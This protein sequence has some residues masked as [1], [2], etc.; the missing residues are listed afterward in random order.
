MKKIGN[1]LSLIVSVIFFIHFGNIPLSGTAAGYNE[2]RL[3]IS[4]MDRCEQYLSA[5]ELRAL[6][7]KNETVYRYFYRFDSRDQWISDHIYT[8]NMPDF[9]GFGEFYSFV[10]SVYTSDTVKKLFHDFQ[11]HGRSF[12]EEDGLF[13]ADQALTF[14]AAVPLY[15]PLDSVQIL[16]GSEQEIVF[17]YWFAYPQR[18]W[19]GESFSSESVGIK[20][21]VLKEEGEWR[22][23]EM[24][25]LNWGSDR[26]VLRD[27]Q[28]KTCSAFSPLI[29]MDLY[30]M[31]LQ[32]KIC[33]DSL[34]TGSSA[35]F[36]RENSSDELEMHLR[37]EQDVGLY[38]SMPLD[39]ITSLDIT[40]ECGCDLSFLSE[41]KA[42]TSLS[43]SNG[44]ACAGREPMESYVRSF[45]FLSSLT[46]LNRLHISGVKDF[47]LSCLSGLP[48]LN[49]IT[50]SACTVGELPPAGSPVKKLALYGCDFPTDLLRRFPDLTDLEIDGKVDDFS[51]LKETGHLR[52]L[53]LTMTGFSDIEN[54]AA[55]N[56]L[57]DLTVLSREGAEATPLENVE[58]LK[59]LSGLKKLTVYKGALS[60][61]QKETV[62]SLLPNCEIVEYEAP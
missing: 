55:C 62:I 29:K 18:V 61:G 28:L 44:E 60:V 22:L 14:T 5:E 19:S 58:Y 20:M 10:A 26:A 32:W 51:F 56:G 27:P 48:E 3:S 11:G 33:E 53:S 30:L 40:A 35:F 24:I 59:E 8:V 37:S 38:A 46:R 6:V 34:S 47:P 41:A 1:W 15:S 45:E 23:S 2:N 52:V 54:L 31:N 7:Q 17:I 4:N 21:S 49:E 13:L 43:V 50:L 25:R 12:F 16:S 9:K 36:P 42:L 39:E 57:T